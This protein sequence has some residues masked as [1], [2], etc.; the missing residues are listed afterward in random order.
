MGVINFGNNTNSNTNNSSTPFA[1]L[2]NPTNKPKAKIWINVGYEAGEGENARFISLPFGIPVDTMDKLDVRGQ[3]EEWVKQRIAQ[4]QLLEA[5]QEMG[6]S[7]DPGREEELNL[8]IRIRR[9]NEEL[10]VDPDTN[11]FSTDLSK[12]LALPKVPEAAE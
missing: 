9:V 4:N 5:L 7:F 12:L 1:G 6:A 2:A 3:N 10:A 8:K 11:E